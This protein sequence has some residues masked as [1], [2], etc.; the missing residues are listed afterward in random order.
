MQIRFYRKRSGGAETYRAVQWPAEC[1][2]HDKVLVAIQALLGKH[3][4][5]R[6]MIVRDRWQSLALTYFQELTKEQHQKGAQAAGQLYRREW[7]V[8]PMDVS[9]PLRVL[10]DATF[11]DEY[12]DATIKDSAVAHSAPQSPHGATAG[13]SGTGRQADGE[14]RTWANVREREASR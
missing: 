1:E 12:V 7:L 9:K 6:A 13:E 10:H 11:C 8:V 4:G 5:G 3:R 2:E 14:A